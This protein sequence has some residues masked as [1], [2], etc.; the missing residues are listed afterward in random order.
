MASLMATPM[1]PAHPHRAY[2]A[3]TASFDDTAIG[4]AAIAKARLHLKGWWG[5][6]RWLVAPLRCYADALP[7]GVCC[8]AFH[9]PNQ[10]RL[11]RG[12]SLSSR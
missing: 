8:N 1:R 2:A 11:H 3:A 9:A 12:L 10:S 5:E 4:S 7:S 6:G